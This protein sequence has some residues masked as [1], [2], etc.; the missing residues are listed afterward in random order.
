MPAQGTGIDTLAPSR[1]VVGVSTKGIETK[2]E[3][4]DLGFA[5]C[6]GRFVGGSAHLAR[7]CLYTL[8]SMICA[9][10]QSLL[11]QA[12]S[13][14]LNYGKSTFP[15]RAHGEEKLIRSDHIISCCILQLTARSY[16]VPPVWLPH[17]LCGCFRRGGESGEPQGGRIE[18]RMRSVRASGVFGTTTREK[19]GTRS[20]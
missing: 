18:G 1:R 12:G 9:D 13:C 5:R 14:M 10:R 16:S 7:S 19:R 8:A 20:G 17:H 15:S 11:P 3:F 2:K 6:D 4:K